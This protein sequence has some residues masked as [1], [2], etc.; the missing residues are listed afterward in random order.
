M[1]RV[2]EL[3][4]VIEAR[5][6][7]MLTVGAALVPV[8]LLPLHPVIIRYKKRLGITQEMDRWACLQTFL[9]F[10]VPFQFPCGSRLFRN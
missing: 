8:K 1:V 4:G 6:A 2:E 5:L 3:P 7:V 9:L 10:T